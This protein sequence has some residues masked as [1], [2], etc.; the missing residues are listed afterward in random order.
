[1]EGVGNRAKARGKK[2]K[3]TFR[4]SVVSLYCVCACVRARDAFSLILGK[5]KNDEYMQ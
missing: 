4:S 1:M 2:V 5:K 3:T